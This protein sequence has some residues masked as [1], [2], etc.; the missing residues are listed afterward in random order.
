MMGILREPFCELTC[1]ANGHMVVK[2]MT[3][4]EEHT[5]S[6]EPGPL[7]WSKNRQKARRARVS[8]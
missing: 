8:A 6:P 4:R 3:A 5:Q 7:W 2:S 1:G